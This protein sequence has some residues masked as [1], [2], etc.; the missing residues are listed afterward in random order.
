M[1]KKEEESFLGPQSAC[2]RN[3]SRWRRENVVLC[4][5]VEREILYL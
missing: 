1:F 2:R 3:S 5:T 4:V